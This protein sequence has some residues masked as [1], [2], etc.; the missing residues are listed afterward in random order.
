MIDAPHIGNM[1]QEFVKQNR[2]YKSG[3][4]K[5]SNVSQQTIANYIKTPNMQVATLFKI[6]QVLKHNFFE[7]IAAQLQHL[8]PGNTPVP[9]TETEALQK[10]NQMLKIQLE[11]LKEALKLVGK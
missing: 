10:E 5:Q 11:T 4:A 8:P 3:W 9:D 1:L 2:I 7:Q 6:C